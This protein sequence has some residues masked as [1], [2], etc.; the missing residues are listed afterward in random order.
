[1]KKIWAL[2][3]AFILILALTACGGAQDENAVDNNSDE[4][5]I[6]AIDK[7][8]NESYIGV[9]ESKNMRFTI[10]KGGVGRYEQPNSDMG[11]FDFTYE[12]EDE[13]LTME[14]TGATMDYSASFEL[15]DDGSALTILH[16][17]LPGYYE[18]ETEFIK[19]ASLD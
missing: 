6:N 2:I 14:L 10:Q 13:V 12:V 5:Y 18:G 1:M 19:V 8:S 3:L 15:N 11:F 16:N 4:S 7:N 9:W 17:G